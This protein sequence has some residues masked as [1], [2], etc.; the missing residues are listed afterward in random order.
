[1][2]YLLDFRYCA[3]IKVA[4]DWKTVYSSNN[5]FMRLEHILLNVKRI[6][7]NTKIPRLEKNVYIFFLKCGLNIYIYI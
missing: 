7:P 2:D 3:R 1:M 6:I 4:I 5:I